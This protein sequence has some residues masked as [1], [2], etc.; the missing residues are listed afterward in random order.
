[1]GLF[2]FASVYSLSQFAQPVFN[3]R[4]YWW[5]SGSRKGPLEKSCK[6]RRVTQHGT[7]L[8]VFTLQKL[9]TP[10]YLLTPVTA[11]AKVIF[12]FLPA[13]R[14]ASAV[15]A[16]TTWLAWCLSDTLQYCV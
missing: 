2:Y 6:G 13:R 16:M 9:F 1:M 12:E 5:R 15:F 8:I 10:F 11:L 14:S 7:A 3:G 4:L